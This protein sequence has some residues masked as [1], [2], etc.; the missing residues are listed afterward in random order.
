MPE[1]SI[2]DRFKDVNIIYYTKEWIRPFA[3][4]FFLFMN[5]VYIFLIKK[6]S[7]QSHC[8]KFRI[9]R[10]NTENKIKINYNAPGRHNS[11]LS[12]VNAI[13]HFPIKILVGSEVSI[14]PKMGELSPMRNSFYIFSLKLLIEP[15]TARVTM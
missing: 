10:K 7:H 2:T 3:P 8:R 13:P 9:Y 15:R 1:L 5:K 4:L 12:T 6:V 14:G 11:V